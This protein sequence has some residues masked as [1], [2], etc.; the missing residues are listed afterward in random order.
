MKSASGP[1]YHLNT[2]LWFPWTVDGIF[3]QRIQGE[4]P[5]IVPN[6]NLGGGFKCFLFSAR[7]WGKWSNLTCAYFSNGFVQLIQ[8]PT[9]NRWA[10]LLSTWNWNLI[11]WFQAFWA[12]FYLDETNEFVSVSNAEMRGPGVKR[13]DLIWLSVP[14]GWIEKEEPSWIGL[15]FQ[16]ICSFRGKFNGLRD[17][18][19]VHW[20]M[21]GASRWQSLPLH[22]VGCFFHCFRTDITR[23]SFGWLP[24]T[25]NTTRRV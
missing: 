21:L 22:C 7:K 3:I 13:W 10:G 1:T 11:V 14:K 25:I 16:S 5:E 8:T 15:F 9:S 12:A 19:L 23:A 18:N 20:K 24:Y 2:Y 4:S 17:W 6:L